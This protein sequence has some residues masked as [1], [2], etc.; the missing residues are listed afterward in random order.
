[1]VLRSFCKKGVNS[2]YTSEQLEQSSCFKS[3]EQALL[4][5]SNGSN[6]TIKVAN[7][8][9]K[10]SENL[11]SESSDLNRAMIELI[12]LIECDQSS[13]SRSV[14]FEVI[15]DERSGIEVINFILFTSSIDSAA[16]L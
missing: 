9:S 16:N 12:T 8:T 7:D 3:I 5:I 2:S 4:E 10:F 11:K 6:N 15:K 14:K 1:L 13:N